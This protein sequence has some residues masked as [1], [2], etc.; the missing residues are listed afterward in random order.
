MSAAAALG[1]TARSP[2]EQ[3]RDDGLV[4]RLLGA[5]AGRFVPIAPAV[6]ELIGAVPLVMLMVMDGAGAS[7]AGVAGAIGWLVLFGGLASGRPHR[8]SVR[9]AAPPLLRAAEYGATLWIGAVA[10]GSSQPAAFALICA[11]AFRHY[12]LVY[13]FRH[14]GRMAP[15]WVGVVGLGWDGRLIIGYVLLAAGA[16]PAGYYALAA[17]FAVL[18]AGE[19]IASWRHFGRAEQPAPYD[20]EEDIAE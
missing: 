18:F 11:L 4:A 13:R 15:T 14:Q 1:T 9:W 8:D 20:D 2:V 16:L 5:A 6:L 12:D 7:N 10:G 3:Y 19:S 17:I